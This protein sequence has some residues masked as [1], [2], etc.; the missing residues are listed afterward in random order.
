L[1]HKRDNAHATPLP[2]IIGHEIGKTRDL[3]SESSKTIH[4][5]RGRPTV[6]RQASGSRTRPP[7]PIFE[8]KSQTV[9]KTANDQIFLN[10][11]TRYCL[12]LKMKKASAVAGKLSS[13]FRGLLVGAK[14]AEVNVLKRDQ[15]IGPSLEEPRARDAAFS[16]S[17]EKKFRA[18]SSWSSSSFSKPSLLSLP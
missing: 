13:Y 2:L 6:N 4:Q 3:R 12:I 7:H 17:R 5:L 8:P 15:V 18:T 10:Q 1:I 9:T 11:K 14:A 16:A